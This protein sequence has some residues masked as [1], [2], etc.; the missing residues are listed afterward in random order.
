L[1]TPAT[2]RYA[3]SLS[4]IPI[5]DPSLITTREIDRAK[6][7]IRLEITASIKAAY[8]ISLIK[9]EAAREVIETRLR[10]MDI[11]HQLLQD[12]LKF[13]AQRL[14]VLL[15]EKLGAVT[16]RI[17]NIATQIRERDIRV[18]QDKIT[19]RAA[20][21]AA[22]T[23]QREL[24]AQRS[25]SNAEA[26]G[27]SE[28]AF[29]KQIENLQSL[30]SSTKD[31]THAQIGNLTGRLDRGEGGQSGARQAMQ[32]RQSNIGTVVGIVGSTIGALGFI[33]A[34]SLGVVN[35]A[36]GGTGETNGLA[37]SN[38]SKLEQLLQSLQA[39]DKDF[40]RRLS[41]MEKAH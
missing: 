18:E 31:A 14:E 6:T 11:T 4:N 16:I 15:S 37:A 38:A 41:L 1:A 39:H 10:G 30:I 40:D 2:P 27:K 21:E 28:M 23:A 35:L 12:E 33:A 19:A 25:V 24:S 29:G 9:T 22:L 20:V 13:Q 7:D 36:K 8:D 3:Q 34:L 17:E 32:D 26:I 5:P